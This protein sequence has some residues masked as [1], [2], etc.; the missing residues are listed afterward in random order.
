MQSTYI[1]STTGVNARAFNPEVSGTTFNMLLEGSELAQIR[2]FIFQAH[3][4]GPMRLLE[5]LGEI[6]FDPPRI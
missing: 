3:S 1:S 6:E 4:V 5:A 2:V